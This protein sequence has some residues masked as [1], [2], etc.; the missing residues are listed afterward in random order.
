[1]HVEPGAVQADPVVHSALAGRCVELDTLDERT[2]GSTP[3][4][5]RP[6]VLYTIG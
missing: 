4:L 6:S 5:D 1:V 2:E 3:L